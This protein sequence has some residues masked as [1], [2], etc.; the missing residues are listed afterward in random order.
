MRSA[1][2]TSPAVPVDW[3]R[4]AI[5]SAVLGIA[6][7]ATL[8]LVAGLF[9]AALAA[10][11]GHLARHETLVHPLRGRRLASIGLLF[12]YGS[13]LLFPVVALVVALSFPALEKWRSDQSAESRA[14]SRAQASR[15][16]VACEGYARANR[17]RYPADWDSL[18]GRYVPEAELAALLRSPYPGGARVAFEL[19]AHDR[20][21]LEA[22][23]DSVVV[24]QEIAPS[25]VREIAVVYAN[26]KVDSLHNPNYDLP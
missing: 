15:L 23:A 2:Q 26:G 13:M 10:I 17:D 8:W 9:A 25:N 18:G 16:F 12:G 14:A 19:V 20:P 6:G 1:P 3:S 11:L 21:V 7:F 4:K 24:I 22:I 5:A